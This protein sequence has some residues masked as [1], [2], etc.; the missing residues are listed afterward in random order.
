[1]IRRLLPLALAL[2]LLTA[3]ATTRHDPPPA[4]DPVNEPTIEGAVDEAVYEG[5]VQAAKGAEIGRRVGTVAGV[6][7]AVL[8]GGNHDTVD[9]ALDRFWMTRD[10][11]EAIGAVI[12]MA[13]GASEGGKRGLEFDAQFAELQQ[14][15]GVDAIRPFTDQIQV[16]LAAAPTAETLDALAAVF[17]DREPRAIDIEAAGDD[18]LD[19]RD[20]LIDRGLAPEG[21]SVR[22][23]E[24]GEG[25][26][27]RIT[28]R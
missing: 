20:A 18:A 1:M 25:I 14:I 7:A 26:T 2:S 21:L 12:G 27:L 17:K 6:F 9:E 13:K 8:G 3:C 23:V 28:Y 24:G 11:A 10:A 15:E 22:R 4:I 16:H 19:V 5:S